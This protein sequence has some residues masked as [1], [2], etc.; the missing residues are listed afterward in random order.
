MDKGLG[1]FVAAQEPA[2]WEAGLTLAAHGVTPSASGWQAGLGFATFSD[3]NAPSGLLPLFVQGA[4][5]DARAAGLNC[6]AVGVA[7]AWAEGLDWFVRN[8]QLVASAGL[9]VTVL[10]SGSNDGAVPY[11]RA[12]SLFAR[13][14]P[15]AALTLHVEAEGATWSSGVPVTAW[16]RG[17]C[18][19]G[20]PLAVRAVVGHAPGPL[21]LYARGW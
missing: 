4:P 9:P 5:S 18:D 15:A 16:G 7:H 14:D 13:R 20:V 12:L 8:D 1:W 17:A 3:D 21:T 2:A 19:S 6:S 11:A 10:G